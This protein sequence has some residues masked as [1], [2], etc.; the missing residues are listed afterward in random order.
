MNPEEKYMR[1]CLQLAISG[2]SNA[3]PN[4]VVGA[5]IVH[6]D[7]IIGEGF[8]SVCGE[9]HAEVNAINSV[10]DKRLLKD[11]TIYV[12]LEPCSHHG[13]TPPCAELIIREGIPRVVVGMQDPFPE[14]AGRGIQ[15]LRDAGV[16]VHVGLLEDNCKKINDRFIAFHTRKRPYIILKWAQTSDGF[17]DILR[18]EDENPNAA[19]ISNEITQIKLHKFRS[20]VGGIMVGTNTALKDNPSLTVRLW[21]GRNPVRIV[22]DRNLRIPETYHLL[23]GKVNTLVFTSK[24]K[25]SAN[26]NIQYIP[27]D[28]DTDIISQILSELYERNIQSILVE[29]GRKLLD[30]FIESALWDEARIEISEKKFGKGVP[31]PVLCSGELISTEHFG[32]SMLIS[33]KNKNH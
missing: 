17:I 30:S 9:A 33:L 18:N 21:K 4:P 1:R 25:E 7:V 6:D 13:K 28:F 27:I 31:A 2:R 24:E 22:V 14:V 10:K 29:G 26:V 11:S 3:I 23:D 8:H 15:M 19:V 20:Q 16:E 12:S 32:D 5:V